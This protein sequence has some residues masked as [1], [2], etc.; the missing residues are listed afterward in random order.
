MILYNLLVELVLAQM[1][2]IVI[3]EVLFLI[4]NKAILR[5]KFSIKNLIIV[6]TASI[7]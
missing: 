4:I 5:G 6:S 1:L 2:I 3:F 7:I